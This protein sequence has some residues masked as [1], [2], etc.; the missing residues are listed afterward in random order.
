MGIFNVI[1]V[2]IFIDLNRHQMVLTVWGK[3]DIL[4]TLAYFCYINY[5]I[6]H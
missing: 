3:V 1:I 5:T 4:L 6:K 2:G